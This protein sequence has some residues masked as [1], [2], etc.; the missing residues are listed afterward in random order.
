MCSFFSPLNKMTIED[1]RKINGHCIINGYGDLKL[2][3]LEGLG[4]WGFAIIFL[5][6]FEWGLY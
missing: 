4:K 3:N 2:E 5:A 6:W 1:R